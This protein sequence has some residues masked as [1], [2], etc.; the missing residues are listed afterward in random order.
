MML[1][2]EKITPT[3]TPAWC[4]PSLLLFSTGPWS[5]TPGAADS[6]RRGARNF[7][8]AP[9]HRCRWPWVTRPLTSLHARSDAPNDHWLRAAAVVYNVY[10]RTLVSRTAADERARARVFFVMFCFF[11]S[12][13][14]K[15]VVS[16]RRESWKK[17]VCLYTHEKDTKSDIQISVP[18]PVM[19]YYQNSI[20]IN[21]R[22]RVMGILRNRQCWRFIW[23]F[24]GILPP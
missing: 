18:V 12:S 5:S 13:S 20:K 10:D 2:M 15:M 23:S 21:T 19:L 8:A 7:A 4:S 3:R 6:A 22:D 1:K 24:Y 16:H 9:C 11:F 14:N 17:R